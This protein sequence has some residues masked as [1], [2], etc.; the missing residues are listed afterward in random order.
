MRIYLIPFTLINEENEREIK[1]KT[2]GLEL[3]DAPN[4]WYLHGVLQDKFHYDRAE[5]FVDYETYKSDIVKTKDGKK[6]LVP[7]IYDVEVEGYDKPCKAFMWQSNEGGITLLRGLVV[8]P[9][10]EKDLE[11]AQKKYDEKPFIL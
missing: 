4:F 2:F 7:G 8:D 9:T 11:Y 5:M 1:K 3:I 10:C 6:Y